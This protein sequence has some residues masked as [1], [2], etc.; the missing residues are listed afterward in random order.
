MKSALVVC[1]GNDLAA[2]D[3]IGR[4][5][6]EKLEGTLPAGTNSR[7]LG[8]GGMALL[9]EFGGEDLLV[10][11]DAVQFGSSPGTVHVLDWDRLPPATLRPVSAHG[12]G[13]RETIEVSKRLFPEQTPRHVYLVGIEGKCFNQLGAGLS[14]D[15]ADAVDSAVSEVLHLLDR[16][17]DEV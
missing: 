5:I 13:I 14:S 15:V 16:N 9:D 7:F 3:G 6:Y 10:V 8:T 11:V 2:D 1:I 4:V 17:L 12:I